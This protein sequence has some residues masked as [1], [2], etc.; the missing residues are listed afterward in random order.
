MRLLIINDNPEDRARLRR[1]L[2]AGKREWQFM[3]TG[4]AI[5]GLRLIQESTTGPPGCVLFDCRL[6]EAEAQE[7]LTAL[8]GPD[9]PR[10]PVVVTGPASDLDGQAILQFGAQD[11]IDKGRLNP[12]SL[13]RCVENAIERHGLT[14]GLRE[15]EERLALATLHNGVGIWDWNLQTQELVWDDSMY[16]L[17]HIRPKDFSGAVDAWKSPCTG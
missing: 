9:S 4:N 12:E 11:F 6:H 10:C 3:E 15:R 7:L 17:Y 13:N 16:A 8:G 14:H 5:A 2:L 1:L